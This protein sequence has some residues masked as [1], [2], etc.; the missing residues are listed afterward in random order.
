MGPKKGWPSLT[1]RAVWVHEPE[2]PPG[3]EPL[4]WMLLTDL[5]VSTAAEAWEKVAWYCRRWG[6]EEWHRVL[7]SICKVEQREFRTA[8]HLQRGLAFDMIMAWRILALMK[9]GRALPNVPAS[10]LYTLEELE[11]L[12]RAVKKK[13]SQPASELTLGEA[14]W[15]VAKLGGW[16][17]RKG[18]GEPGAE[19]LASG[20]R[21]LQDMVQG[22]RL[23]ALPP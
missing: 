4:D 11:V 14:N 1:L 8:E 22:W 7:K 13:T 17:G 3:I 20:L 16:L 23:H 6:I 10:L 21:R 19:S 15:M 2:P 9:L 18:D 5:P 12:S